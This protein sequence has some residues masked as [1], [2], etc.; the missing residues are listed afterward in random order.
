[1][2]IASYNINGVTSRLPILLR[3]L[4]EFEPDVVGLQELK[5]TDEKFPA[6]EI[7]AAGYDVIWHGQKSWNGV[8][9]LS[10][11]GEPVETRRGLP[12]D[13]DR[14]QSRYIEAAVCGVLVGNMYAPNGNPW[15]GPKFDYKLAWLERLQAHAQDLLDSK[16]P[17]I[18]I[19]DYNVIPTDEDVYKPENWKKDALFAP[20]AKQAY[21]EL[22]AQGWTDAI[23][24]LHPD[25]RIYT[26]WHYWRN[27]FARDAGIRIDHAL[28]SPALAKGLKAAGVDRTP[29]GWDKTSDHAPMWVEVEV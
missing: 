17:A 22:V 12:G 20:E 27:S 11:V 14:N 24:K 4:E 3:W 21:A 1:M 16:A 8:A 9:L 6:S 28:L 26:F 7:R 2:R 25:E 5:T 19:G 23:R 10:R 15:P 29:R 13:P 18:L